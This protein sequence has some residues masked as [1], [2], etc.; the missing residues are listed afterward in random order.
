VEMAERSAEVDQMKGATLEQISDMVGEIG[1][2]FKSKQAQLNP[3][4]AELKVNHLLALENFM[5]NYND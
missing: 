1:R 3:L 2:E 5:S 4:M